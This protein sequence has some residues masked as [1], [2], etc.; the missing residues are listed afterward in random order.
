MEAVISFEDI[1][2]PNISS[3]SKV[4]SLQEKALKNKTLLERKLWGQFYTG[5]AVS[6]FMASWIQNPKQ[7]HLRLLDAGAGTGILTVSSA[8]H[9]LSKGCLSVHATLYE[10]DA[11]STIHLEE[12]MVMV[13]DIFSAHQASFSFEIHHKDFIM[14]RPDKDE[15]LKPF[16]I[17]VINPPY[18]KYKVKESPYGKYLSDL[19]SGDPNIYASFLAVT[20]ACLRSGG[21]MIAITPRSFTNGLYFKGFRTYLLAHSAL[22]RIHVFKR[23]DKV[24]QKGKSSVLQENIICQFIKGSTTREVA[25]TSSDCDAVMNA[26]NSDKYSADLI[27]DLSN[28]HQM[29]RIPETGE[30]AKLLKQAESLQSTFERSGYYISTGRVVEHRAREYV[31]EPAVTQSSV[32]LYRPHNVMPLKAVWTGGHKKDVSFKLGSNKEKYV[33]KN[34]TY[35]LLKRFSSKDEK[36]RLVSGVYSA[37][38]HKCQYICF[39]NKVNYLGVQGEIIDKD[40]AYGLS[41]IFNS[42]FMDNY[43]RCISGN[44]QVNATEIRIMRFPTRNQVKQIG[45][46]LKNMKNYDVHNVDLVV[47]KI[48]G[49]K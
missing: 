27:I 2:C 15:T 20:L 29:I 16:D 14:A 6:N 19:Y 32:P 3:M 9:C 24:F 22:H 4:L 39:G 42:Q 33:L 44:T 11:E 30:E 34:Q 36:R 49:I 12:A 5:A 1:Q 43:F 23:R 26:A 25:I 45:M 35:V 41:A 48:L 37:E 10:S 40:E 31:V 13:Q 28:E 47:N 38:D 18:F 21:E 46:K 8:L 17:A 7:K